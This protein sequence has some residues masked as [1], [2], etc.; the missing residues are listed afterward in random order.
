MW[1]WTRLL[2]RE[3]AAVRELEREQG[4][5]RR[6]L[7]RQVGQLLCA[8]P[9]SS[10]CPTIARVSGVAS[11]AVA[12]VSTTR[13]LDGDCSPVWGASLSVGSTGTLQSRLSGV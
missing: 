13:S 5:R 6:W 2:R 9:T 11:A 1:R 7:Q 4:R 8:C 12:V 10:P 3:A